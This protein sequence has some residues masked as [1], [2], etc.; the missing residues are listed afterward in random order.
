MQYWTPTK[1]LHQ[2]HNTG[3]VR[4]WEHNSNTQPCVLSRATKFPSIFTIRLSVSPQVQTRS[5]VSGDAGVRVWR[6]MFQKLW[7]N[8]N[9]SRWHQEHAVLQP[10]TSRAEQ[11]SHSTS[12]THTHTHTGST[13]SSL[14]VR[15]T[16]M[17]GWSAIHLESQTV[18]NSNPDL[19][20]EPQNINTHTLACVN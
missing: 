17:N 9:L 19:N 8:C 6:G 20:S 5:G 15:R 7:Q 13:L 10:L 12:Y 18:S 11:G 4:H 14:D 16:E 2:K 1:R 3:T